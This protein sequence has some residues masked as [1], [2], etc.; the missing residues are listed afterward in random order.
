MLEKLG[1]KNMGLFKEK[2]SEQEKAARENCEA[3]MQSKSRQMTDIQ[4]IIAAL[5]EMDSAESQVLCETFAPEMG[6]RCR[7]DP[8]KEV[9]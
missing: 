4:L 6:R 1:D 8:Y 2:E 3:Q 5:L 9:V 7:Y